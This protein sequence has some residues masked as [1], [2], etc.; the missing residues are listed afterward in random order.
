MTDEQLEVQEVQEIQPEPIE[1]PE[2]EDWQSKYDALSTHVAELEK[3]LADRAKADRDALISQHA[4]ERGLSNIEEL[5]PLLKLDE[6]SDDE[7]PGYL[8]A[9]A[10]ALP[11]KKSQPIG[12]ST[13]GGASE[14]SREAVIRDAEAR[15]KRTG[16][17]EDVAAF[18]LAKKITQKLGGRNA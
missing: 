14:R 11:I 8:D 12:Q 15:A 13:N 16:S 2:V 9:L 6:V 17:L 18:S 10:Q 5:R 7:L 4:S 1:E 3:Q